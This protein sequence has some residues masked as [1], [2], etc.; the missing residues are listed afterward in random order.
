MHKIKRSSKDIPVQGHCTSTHADLTGLVKQSRHVIKKTVKMMGDLEHHLKTD[1][2][3]HLL[4]SS[5]SLELCNDE[6]PCCI[7]I[8][9]SYKEH[10]KII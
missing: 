9:I 10:L 1:Q 6:I 3:L 8:F 7:Y 2:L 4:S 5:Q